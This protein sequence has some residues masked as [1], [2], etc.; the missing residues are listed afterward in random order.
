MSTE[1]YEILAVKY[2]EL[3]ERRRRDNFIFADDHDRPDPI[4]YFVWVIRSPARTIVVDTG[5]DEAEGR[6][7]GRSVKR[8]PAEALSLLGIDA[9]TVE[10][11]IVTHG[12]GP[13]GG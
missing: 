2:A 1:T 9:E 7:R 5:F 11:V 10:Q 3:T 6:K 12:H 8:A 13:N 4:D